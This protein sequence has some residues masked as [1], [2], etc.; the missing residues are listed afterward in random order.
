LFASDWKIAPATASAMPTMIPVSTR[1][2]RSVCTTNSAS[3]PPSP[4]SALITSRIGIGK[5]PT[6]IDQHPTI[7]ISNARTLPTTTERLSTRIDHRP[8][9]NTC[10]L[11]DGDLAVATDV[12]RS[13]SATPPLGLTVAPSEHGE[14][15]TRTP[16]RPS[17]PS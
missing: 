5:S 12:A 6:L 9:R 17:Q 11:T 2:R 16:G 3:S 10:P 4:R 14:R 15:G 1:G 7:T 13:T 8:R